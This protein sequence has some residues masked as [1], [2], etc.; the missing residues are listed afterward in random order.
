M[1]ERKLKLQELKNELPVHIARPIHKL[2]ES[3]SFFTKL[4]LMSDSLM[5]ILRING[6]FLKEIYLLRF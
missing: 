5:G 1:S 6:S 3:E 4:Y 2:L